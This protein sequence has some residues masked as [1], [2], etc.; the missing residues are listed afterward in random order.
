M[1]IIIKTTSHFH[2]DFVCL[3]RMSITHL[4]L[5]RINIGATNLV[6]HSNQPADCI[7]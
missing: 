2:A 4:A 7:Y 5:V 3:K 6:N 1:L